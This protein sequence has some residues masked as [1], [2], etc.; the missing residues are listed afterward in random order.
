VSELAVQDQWSVSL[1]LRSPELTYSRFEEICTFLGVVN[2]E[3]RFA[4]GDAILMGPE[5]FGA[6]AYQALENLQ[7]SEDGRQEYARV[8][9]KVPPSLR[10]KDISWS[11]HRAV[12][13]IEGYDTK[14]KILKRAADE[15]L[16]HH[17]LRDELRNGA[18]PRYSVS[19]CRCCGREL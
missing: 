10:R 14:K 8:S 4:I 7:L 17:A 2:T 1:E 9:Q 11:H 18:E 19:K 5:L 12:A 6:E 3:V 15:G 13:S 16:T